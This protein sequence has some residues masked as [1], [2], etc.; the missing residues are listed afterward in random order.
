M[1]VVLDNN[2][3]IHVMHNQNAGPLHDPATGDLVDR[4]PE[5]ADALVEQI[6]SRRGRLIV[7][8][9]VLTEYLLGIDPVESDAH[10][11]ELNSMTAIEFMPFDELAAIECAYMVNAVER[12]QLSPNATKAKLR[13]DR[14]ILAICKA[15]G[16]DELWTHDVELYNKA[17]EVDISSGSLAD[18]NP[19]PRQ[20][21]MQYDQ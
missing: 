10:V 16:V 12:S 20:Y 21:N 14:Q 19:T 11:R 18:I 8:T 6:T 3:L 7:P 13:F 4:L 15:A 2:V 9:P 5:R 1:R 17:K